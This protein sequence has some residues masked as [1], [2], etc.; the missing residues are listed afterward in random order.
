MDKHHVERFLEFLTIGV[1]MGVI[2]DLIAVKLATG[3]TID[4]RMIGVVLLVAI[5]FAA[6]S[7][8]IVD[9]DDFRFPEKIANRISSD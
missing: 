3:E 4:L 2:E 1:L 7:E 8:L 9:H 6:F 5:P